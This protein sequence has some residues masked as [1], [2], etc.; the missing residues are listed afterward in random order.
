[1]RTSAVG[2][3][4][5]DFLTILPGAQRGSAAQKAYFFEGKNHGPKDRAE[6]IS[7]SHLPE[8]RYI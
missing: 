1:M 2:S 4:N 5:L 8:I 6:C 7:V 3:S